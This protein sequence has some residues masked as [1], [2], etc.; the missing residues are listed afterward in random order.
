M[1]YQY[2]AYF[3]YKRDPESDD[4]HETVKKK[5]QHWAAVDLGRE[6][7][8]FFDR[9]DILTGVRFR[10]TLADALRTSRCIICLWSPLYFQSQWCLSEFKSFQRREQ[11]IGSSLVL[12]AS[13]FDGKTFPADATEYQFA[14]FSPFAITT[15]TFWHTS[16]AVTFERTLLKRFAAALARMIN[17]AP[18]YDEAFPIVEIEQSALP[19]KPTFPRPADVRD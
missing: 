9:D 5:L 17:N 11:E 1:S 10:N 8:I 3:S 16:E 14:D 13:Y 6:L 19:P 12:P 2:D 4:W 18:P 15:P 7:R